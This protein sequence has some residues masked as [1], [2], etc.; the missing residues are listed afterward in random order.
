MQNMRS[1]I[2]GHNNRIISKSKD[3][4]TADTKNLCNCRRKEDC[5]LSGKCLT[6]SIVYAANITTNTS[7]KTYIGMTGGEFKSRFN[8]HKKAFTNRKYAKDTELSKYIWSLKEN[9]EQFNIEWKILRHAPA[10]TNRIQNRCSLCLE[11]KLAIANADKS[12]LL[13]KRSELISKCRHFNP[14]PSYY[15]SS[16]EMNSNSVT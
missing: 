6:R 5:P 14:K 4:E 13:N 12:L 8:N 9:N 2:Q 15:I 11:E 16:T 1:I 3:S 10:N 7:T